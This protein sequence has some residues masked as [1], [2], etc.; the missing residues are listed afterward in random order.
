MNAPLIKTDK[1]LQPDHL[2]TFT[3]RDFLKSTALAAGAFIPI[4]TP[5]SSRQASVAPGNNVNSQTLATGWEY[6]RGS[7]GSAWDVWRTDEGESTVWQQVEV[8]HCFNARDAVDPDQPYYEGPA[9]YRRRLQL[10]NPFPH[11]RTLLQFEGAGQKSEIFVA[12]ERVGTHIGGYDEFVID[13]TD[14]SAQTVKNVLLGGDIPLAVLCDN[15]RD[16]ETIPSALNDFHRFGGL[17]RNVTL[18]YVPAISLER[19]HLAVELSR[20]AIAQVTIKARLHNPALL[21]DEV[22]LL[23]R[24]FDPKN[25]LVRT[26]AR[27]LSPW[28]GEAV[29][30]DFKLENPE[31]W[32]PLHPSLYLCEVQLA[33]VHGTMSTAERFGCR[34]FEFVDHG[35]FKLNG[36]QLLLKGT[37]REEDHAGLG[38]A[39]PESLIRQEMMLIKDMGANFVGLAHHQQSR[40]V[41]DLC[42]ELGLLALEE[43]PWSRGG[44][45]GENYKGQA[46]NMLRAM[47]DQHYNHPSVIL[48]GVGNEND[49]AGDFPDFD[50]QA[51]RGFMKELNDEAHA[52]DP[53]RRTFLR[54]CDFC[55][56]LVDVYSPSLWAGWYHGPYTQ[57]RAKAEHE[58]NTVSHFLHVE[59]G[60]E[61]HA[62]R[63][64]EDVDG[65]LANFV[66]GKFDENRREYLLTGGAMMGSHD[67]DWSETYACNLFDWHLKEQENMH[68]V[69]GSAQWIFKDFSTPLRAENPIPHVNQKGLTQR[70]L[71]LKEGYYT[72]QSYWSEKPMVH[73][74]GHSWSIRWG[75][76][77]E[78]KL[79]KVYSNCETAELFLNGISQG[80]RKRN[81]Q[82][83]PA[84]GLHW[85]V[86][87]Q[88]GQNH[89]KTVG[90]RKGT[91]VEDE[92]ILQYQVEDWGPPQRLELREVKR[93]GEKVQVEARLVDARGKQ[94]LRARD[95]VRFGLTGDGVLLDNQGTA[96]GSRSVELCNG[97]AEMSLL[98]NRGQ[99]VISAHIQPIATAFLTVS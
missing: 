43:I 29:I 34:Y 13:I 77:D 68:R 39:M 53:S 48:W 27:R 15:S 7:L 10:H 37:H 19:V 50:K 17:Y 92:V 38:A 82:D 52:L 9:W 84:A 45:G 96:N 95:R 65:L 80:T 20:P 41:L 86:R 98:T 35:P 57:Y 85:L 26:A 69:P 61:S 6:F 93:E 76:L 62:G 49:W 87:F 90:H 16:S 21:R 18:S 1:V 72:F 8:P 47:I 99:S 14:A 60:A 42:D 3:R 31:L 28:E 81:S 94:C 36:E 74:Y 71:T 83:F 55:K 5:V 89:L 88:A 91:S 79:V 4:F 33:S 66:S 23:I 54:R 73:I 58:M 56:D 12:N 78:A 25:A 70:D 67:G 63:H 97:R 64:S 40:T 75:K 22:H 51:I 24:I 30:A 46:R 2:D 11:G 44:L 32:S 59:W